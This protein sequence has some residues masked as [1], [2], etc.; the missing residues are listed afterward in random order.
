MRPIIKSPLAWAFVPA[1]LLLLYGGYLLETNQPQGQ[2]PVET[3]TLTKRAGR[4]VR[5]QVE[6]AT[7]PGEREKGL[8]FRRV[9]AP[10]TGMLFLFPRAQILDF[11]MKNTIVPLDMI[12]IGPR[13]ELDSMALNQAPLSLTNA[14]SDDPAIAVIEVPA[15]TVQRLGLARGDRVTDL[16]AL[17]PS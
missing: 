4:P 3:I 17:P 10:D 9:L 8:M 13:G 15:G 16:G 14:F 6:M 5:L 1:T 7:T 12:F 2:L 11:W